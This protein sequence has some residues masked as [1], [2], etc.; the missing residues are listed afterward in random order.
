[1]LRFIN[2][3]TGNTFNGD[4]P[5]VF[6]FPG[7]QST[8]IYYTNKICCI[9]SENNISIS[10][11][12]N[13]IFHLVDPQKIN[14]LN[15][16]TTYNIKDILCRDNQY[17]SGGVYYRGYYIHMIYII[18]SSSTEGEFICELSINNIAYKI[19]ADFYGEN[20]ALYI[21]LSNKG[22]NIPRSIQ[23]AIYDSN[24]HEDKYDNI[25]LNRKWKELLSNYW[26]VVANKGSYKSL[27]NSLKWFEYGQNIN[28]Y[29]IWKNYDDDLMTYDIRDL[30]EV[31]SDKYFET[32][33]NTCK[34]TYIAIYMA[35][36]EME[37]DNNKMLY[38]EEKNPLLKNISYK[39]STED[40]ALKM[41]L[42]GNFY[43]TYFMPI[44]L[45]LIHATIENIVFSNNFK[46]RTGTLLKRDD[47][48]YNIYPLKSNISDG[49]TFNLTN[50]KAYVGKKTLFGIL[51]EKGQTYDD[52]TPLGVSLTPDVLSDKPDYEEFSTYSTQNYDAIGALVNYKISLYLSENDFINQEVLNVIYPDNTIHHIVDNKIL[53]DNI[54]FNILC[55]Q[56][57]Q[58][59]IYIQFKSAGGKV[60]ITRNNINVIDT[61]SSLI[62][63]YKI[64]SSRTYDIFKANPNSRNIKNLNDYIF[65][66]QMRVFPQQDTNLYI[67]YIPAIINQDSNKTGIRLNHLLIIEGNIQDNYISDN[68][69][70]YVTN[71]GGVEYT[72]CISKEFGFSPNLKDIQKKY[73]IYR[74]DY[75][76]CPEFHKLSSFD[77]E[78]VLEEWEALCIVPDITF[79]H[80]I[81]D[82]E[83]KFINRSSLQ[84]NNTITLKRSICEPFLTNQT[85][86]YLSKGYYDVEF[87]YRLKSS[88][89]IN[90][91]KIRSVFYRK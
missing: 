90:K 61:S 28:I 58:Y 64:I 55:P 50:V 49:M 63:F 84:A 27:L 59:K 51:F 46:E 52:I 76:F 57:G 87:S 40:L 41:T 3:D 11:E 56:E 9:S 77:N 89:D 19:G 1:M 18:A 45:D 10:L 42:L 67:Q 69:Y 25:L 79:S 6:W 91:I 70:T 16:N 21:N 62:K 26:D 47:F 24:V 12:D 80:K 75:I 7:E 4:P 38:D 54:R 5:F 8:N 48:I 68:Y 43:Q 83:W 60:F 36:Q 14:I 31:L 20:E 66:R 35:L 13:N 81:E 2:L 33:Q 29:E 82:A 30:Q 39:W 65:G 78:Y 88:T 85:E 37:Y 23:K 86:E 72:V 71:R 44:H 34:T 32:L 74:H 22:I 17:I 15:N 53:K 73:N